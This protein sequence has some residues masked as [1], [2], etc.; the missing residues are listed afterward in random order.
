LD[1][2]LETILL[3]LAHSAEAPCPGTAGYSPDFAGERTA[4]SKTH[5]YPPRKDE[6]V[7]VIGA[8]RAGIEAEQAA[9]A[10]RKAPA[11]LLSFL[12]Y[13]RRTRWAGSKR[14]GGGCLDGFWRVRGTINCW[15]SRLPR[16]RLE[17]IRD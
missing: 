10:R 11:D 14:R 2:V 1:Q 7:E 15:G 13:T 6:I 3:E 5:C 16:R 17:W 4:L 12:S 9:P 8:L